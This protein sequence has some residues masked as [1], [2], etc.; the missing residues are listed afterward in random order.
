MNAPAPTIDLKRFPLDET[1][2]FYRLHVEDTVRTDVLAR[3][4]E[5]IQDRLADATSETKVNLTS[6][7]AGFILAFLPDKRPL[8]RD[9]VRALAD[10]AVS[11]HI[12]EHQ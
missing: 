3:L 8:T 11:D 4:V 1:L 10:A 9:D 12:K 6:D 5:R 7:G 2:A